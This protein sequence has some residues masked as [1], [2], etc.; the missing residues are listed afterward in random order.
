VT[1]QTGVFILDPSING[2]RFCDSEC[3]QQASRAVTCS[4]GVSLVFLQTS[5]Q[6]KLSLAD[7]RFKSMQVTTLIER[8]K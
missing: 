1:A 4:V 6:T 3:E 5:D 8:T 7:R 2:C